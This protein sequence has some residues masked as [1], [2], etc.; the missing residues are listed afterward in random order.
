MHQ[1]VG[2]IPQVHH[3]LLPSHAD[4][5]VRRGG[6]TSKCRPGAISAVY[7]DPSGDMVHFVVHPLRPKDGHYVLQEYSLQ[8]LLRCLRGRRGHRLMLS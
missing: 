6:G 8:A 3:R 5:R 7:P 1:D 4:H 2:P